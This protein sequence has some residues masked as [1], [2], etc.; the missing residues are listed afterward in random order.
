MH[1]RAGFAEIHIAITAC[2]LTQEMAS[3][4]LDRHTA[5]RGIHEAAHLCTISIPS[6]TDK[7]PTC[8][9]VRHSLKA[10]V[11]LLVAP[12]RHVGA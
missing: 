10:E 3:G 7:Q 2:R 12:A 4:A 8:D 11:V 5:R 9:P 6:P 1:W